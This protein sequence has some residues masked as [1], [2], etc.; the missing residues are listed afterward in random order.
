MTTSDHPPTIDEY[1]RRAADQGF[2]FDVARYAAAFNT[3]AGMRD[4][5]ADLRAVPL[6]YLEPTEPNSALVWIES[7]GVT[8]AGT[9]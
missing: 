1:R 2:V 5:L 3:H 4:A 9:S 6:P 7:G 8:E